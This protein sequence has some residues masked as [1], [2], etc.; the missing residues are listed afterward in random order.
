ME[1]GYT[2]T[3]RFSRADG[4]P[5]NQLPRYQLSEIHSPYRLVLSG[6]FVSDNLTTNQYISGALSWYKCQQGGLTQIYL[7][8]GADSYFSVEEDALPWWLTI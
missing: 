7:Q 6:R 4:L 3:F 1:D 5:L 2:V 8:T